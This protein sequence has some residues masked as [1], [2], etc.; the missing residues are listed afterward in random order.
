MKVLPDGRDWSDRVV[1]QQRV[2]AEIESACAADDQRAGEKSFWS[3]GDDARLAAA[4][5]ELGQTLIAGER[6]GRAGVDGDGNV[7]R[8][9]GG[10]GIQR[11]V[12]ASKVDRVISTAAAGEADGLHVGELDGEVAER[13]TA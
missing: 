8:S 3:G 11:V 2:V 6:G 9:G 4:E 5:R 13:T 1:E 10:V 12:A 7:G